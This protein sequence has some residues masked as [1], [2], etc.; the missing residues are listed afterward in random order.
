VRFD[1]RY[2]ATVNSVAESEVCRQVA[3]DVLGADK[4]R[5]DELPSMGAEDFAYMLAEKPGCYAWLGNGPGSGGCTL[6]NPHYDFN[7]EIL[8]IGISYWVRLA[9]T[10]LKGRREQGRPELLA[11]VPPRRR[12]GSRN[13]VREA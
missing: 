6:H 1:H 8:P 13:V 2:P 11:C 9:E 12:H 10:W 3:R 4:L 5:M 7:D